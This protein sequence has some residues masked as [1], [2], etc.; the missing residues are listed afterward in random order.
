MK[1]VLEKKTVLPGTRGRSRQGKHHRTYITKSDFLIYYD[2]VFPLFHLSL[3]FPSVFNAQGKF[4]FLIP[5][6][7]NSLVPL[8]PKCPTHDSSIAS[9]AFILF[10]L[11]FVS[12]LLSSKLSKSPG[13]CQ[14]ETEHMFPPP[15][16]LA[17]DI[18][19]FSY[20]KLDASCFSPKVFNV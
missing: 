2:N 6:K 1:N 10:N 15:N 13:I 9:P 11:Y 20:V 8:P 14:S 7:Y 17:L 18:R 19:C 16:T 12:I 3:S 5:P 4:L